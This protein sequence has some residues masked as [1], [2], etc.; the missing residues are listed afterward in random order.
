MPI[1]G[2][3]EVLVDV[4]GNPITR[5]NPLPVECLAAPTLEGLTVV[6][7]STVDVQLL[8]ANPNRKSASIY[9]A[10]TN[11]ILYVKFGTGATNLSFKVPLGHQ[12][13]YEFPSPV[14]VGV[15]HGVWEDVVG[16]SGDAQVSEGT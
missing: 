7:H 9:N 4:D 11:S 6:G 14:Y 1:P 15:V 5:D 16:G 2:E 10:S 3:A 12:M 13:Y 8:A